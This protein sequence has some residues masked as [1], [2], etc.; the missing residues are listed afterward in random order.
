MSDIPAEATNGNLNYSQYSTN[1]LILQFSTQDGDNGT[2]P[3]FPLLE[4]AAYHGLAGEIVSAIQPHTEA[5]PAS[6]LL[7]FLAAF[8]NSVGRSPHAIAE[9]DRHGCNLFVCVVGETSKGRKGSS[10]GQIRRFFEEADPEWASDCVQ[11]GLSSG[12]GLIH[13]VRDTAAFDIG[14]EDKR[15]FVVES[16]FVSPLK[17]MSREGNVLSAVIRQAWD[18]G[19]LATLTKNTPTRVRDAHV[20]IIGHTIKEELL[21]YLNSVEMGN[22][23]ANRFLWV[24]SRRAQELPEGGGV[25]ELGAMTDDLKAALEHG[26]DMPLL[27]RDGAARKLWAGVY[28]GL[29]EGAPGLFGA[30]TARA[31][32]QVLRLSVLYAVL[33]GADSIGV[34][35]LKAALAVWQYSESSA[36][37]IFG[38]TTGDPHADRILEAL[39]QN[40]EGL[41]RTRIN[42]LLGN[43]VEK[44]RIERSLSVLDNRGLAKP[45]YT[46][47]SG[48]SREDWRAT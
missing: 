20:S 38:E 14:V 48:R 24:L 47:T 25:P 29:S 10:W 23:F 15:L 1:E 17:Q 6:L 16:E 19:S 27:V 11:S 4:E 39:R 44:P 18:H 37:R 33:D 32:A 2:D 31:E 28:H 26:R 5:D 42:K 12:E 8:G 3:A 13:A 21:R 45:T 34:P 22:G 40:P 36:R 7:H 43:N 35:Q 41:T 30:V 9:A 46:P